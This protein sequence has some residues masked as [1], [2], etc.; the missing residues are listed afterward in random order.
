MRLS[1]GYRRIRG[2]W[3]VA[4]ALLSCLPWAIPAGAQEKSTDKV[5]TYAIS[6]ATGFELYTS[7]GEHGPKGAIA[8][9]TYA[10]T[11]RRLFD[12]EGG[13]CRLVWARPQLAVIY[14]YP[15]PSGKL[16]PKLQPLWDRFIAGV[17]KHEEE[18]GRMIREMV[19]ETAKNIAGA[20]VAND[21][22]CAKV[23]REV[24]RLIDDAKRTYKTRSRQ[25]DHV[26]L[27]EGGNVHRLILALVNER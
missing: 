7:I 16:S 12:E 20:S 27:S 4:L 6:G 14:T 21:G 19:A 3:P 11:W 23:K 17:R 13:S 24:T 25:F 8:Q 10:L 26:E 9:T 22:N 18:H 1:D 15:K 5:K 2:T